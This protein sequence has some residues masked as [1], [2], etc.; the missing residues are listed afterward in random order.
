M[1]A[2]RSRELN[3]LKV[4]P[5]AEEEPPGPPAEQGSS[6]GCEDMCSSCEPEREARFGYVFI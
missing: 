5:M 4:D 6:G 2:R 3:L 1:R